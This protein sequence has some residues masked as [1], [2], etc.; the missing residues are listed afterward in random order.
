MTEVPLS[1]GDSSTSASDG[2]S[3]PFHPE[4]G[5]YLTDYIGPI[6]A[7]GTDD[8]YVIL[9][10]STEGGGPFVLE[11]DRGNAELSSWSGTGL[12]DLR[13]EIRHSR[14]EPADTFGDF[15]NEVML[16]D[17][18]GPFEHPVFGPGFT[19]ASFG[20]ASTAAGEIVDGTH[21]VVA[22][23]GGTWTADQIATML[24]VPDLYIWLTTAVSGVSSVDYW[25]STYELALTVIAAGSEPLRKYP[26]SNGR[27]HSPV[28]RNY[29]P[30]PVRRN[31]GGMP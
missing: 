14:N 16:G 28:R 8:S 22:D 15:A 5:L 13:I 11:N 17:S 12:V 26:R 19:I 18:S 1:I 3:L 7:D 29:P 4:T 10:T 9:A 2:V 25:I 27:G 23:G 30:T 6:W 31:Y 21:L 24:A 20:L